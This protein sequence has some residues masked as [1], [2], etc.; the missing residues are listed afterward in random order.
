M[1]PLSG[2]S[3]SWAIYPKPCSTASSRRRRLV[4]HVEAHSDYRQPDVGHR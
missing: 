1:L 2:S 4:A 3:C